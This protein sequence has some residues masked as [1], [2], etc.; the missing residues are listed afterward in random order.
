VFLLS[1]KDASS[2]TAATTTGGYSSTSNSFT[3]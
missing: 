2:A 1:T 3:Y